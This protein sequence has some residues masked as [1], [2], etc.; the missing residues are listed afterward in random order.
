VVYHYGHARSRVE[1]TENIPVTD[2]EVLDKAYPGRDWKRNVFTHDANDYAHQTYNARTIPEI[3]KRKQ[4]G[5]FII[6]FWGWPQKPIVDAHNDIVSVEPAIGTLNIPCTQHSIFASYAVMHHTYGKHSM[7]PRWY[8]AVVPHYFDLNDFEFN[9]FPKD[10]FLYMGRI[11]YKKGV[12]IAIEMTKRLGA[13]LIVIGQGDLTTICGSDIPDHVKSFPAVEPRL[14]TEFMRNAKALIVPTYYCE[15]FGM[16]V[17][18]A[19]MCG[20]P[21]ISTDWGAFTETNLHGITGFRCRSIEQFVWA[22]KNI[23]KIKRKDC[24]DWAVNNYSLERVA[25]MYQ[26]YF[27]SLSTIFNGKGGFYCEN[28][29]RSELDWLTRYYPTTS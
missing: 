12:D 4:P 3:Q 27:E 21:V 18:E 20:T 6:P 15:P 7:E 17:V 26:E 25:P 1:C 19:L 16:V 11:I 24:R 22:G 2:D 10:Y 9:E 13:K 14:R 29:E 23:D 5:D 8:D 28:S